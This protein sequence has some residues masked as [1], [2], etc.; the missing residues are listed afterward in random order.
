MST[1]EQD[2]LDLRQA[3][4]KIFAD[5][6][7]A[8]LVMEALPPIDYSQ[9]ATKQDVAALRSELKGDF[10]ELKGGVAA[11][12]AR[13]DA[14]IDSKAAESLRVTVLTALSTTVLLGGYITAVLG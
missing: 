3:F 1:N 2:R 14:K 12:L 10:A 7:M 11:D 6:R 8:R 9:L 5:E 13:L 4:E